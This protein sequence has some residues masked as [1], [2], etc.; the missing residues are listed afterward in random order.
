V[1]V[2]TDSLCTFGVHNICMLMWNNKFLIVS[3]CS[4]SVDGYHLKAVHTDCGVDCFANQFC[5]QPWICG[6]LPGCYFLTVCNST[7]V[8]SATVTVIGAGFKRKILS[9]IAKILRCWIG[10][11]RYLIFEFSGRALSWMP[12]VFERIQ[13]EIIRLL[14]HIFVFLYLRKG[15]S[16]LFLGITVNFFD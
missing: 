9:K 12:I 14:V 3:F 1:L 4:A 5:S 7:A 8:T 15:S 13:L 6:N 16:V 2:S 10:S 11:C